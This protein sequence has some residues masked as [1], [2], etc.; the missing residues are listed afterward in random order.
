M[1]HPLSEYQSSAPQRGICFLPRRALSVSDCEIARA[2]KITGTTVEPIAFVVPR[3]VSTY[4]LSSYL[5]RWIK[6]NVHSQSDSFQSDIFPPALSAEPALTAG[7]FF[8]GKT[9][10]PNLVSLEDGAIYA[11]TSTPQLPATKTT[12]PAPT[13]SSSVPAPSPGAAPVKKQDP[14]VQ[15]QTEPAPPKPIAE[16]SPTSPKLAS[17]VIASPEPKIA[18][19]LMSRSHSAATDV[20]DIVCTLLRNFDTRF[21][22]LSDVG[23]CWGVL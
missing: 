2:Y 14:P 15:R 9:A 13:R 21:F 22:F 20:S 6:C 19:G 10:P 11:S 18:P 23:T 16:A 12:P 1:L 5:R 7:E 17:P 3:K 8:S 4:M